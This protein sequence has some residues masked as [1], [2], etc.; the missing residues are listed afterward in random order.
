MKPE[1]AEQYQLFETSQY[2]YRV[3]VTD[4]SESIDFVVWFYR[5]RQRG[6]PDQRGEQRCRFGGASVAPLRREQQSFSVGHAGLQ[7]ELLADA[8]QPRTAGRRHRT[9]AHHAGDL[10]AAL[11]IR[12]CQDLAPRR[13]HWSE[14]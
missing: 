6:K 7:P 12:G 10:T 5:Q 4:F 8:V 1:E 3:F 13:A 9:T 11:P 14:L 2:K